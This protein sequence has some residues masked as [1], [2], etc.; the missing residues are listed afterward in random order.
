[1]DRDKVKQ[2]VRQ[3]IEALPGVV[4]FQFLDKDFKRELVS[5]EKEAESNGACWGLMP[6][7]NKGVWAAMKREEQFVI[8]IEGTTLLLG[9]SNG[10][11]FIEDKTGQV[12]GEWITADR[13]EQLRARD[14]VCF[15]SDDFV[16]YSG[17]DIKGEPRFVL[18]D[19]DFPYLDGV[20]GVENVSS[21]SIST[22]ADDYIRDRLG[23][24]ETKHWTHLVGFDIT[25]D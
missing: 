21:G 22:L 9:V 3:R 18:P 7:V 4:A 13:L 12:V 25:K 20:E 6:F 23:Y 2:E 1:M 19:V 11:V 5:L 14:D 10:L 8:V 17:L 16:L 24:L 15:V